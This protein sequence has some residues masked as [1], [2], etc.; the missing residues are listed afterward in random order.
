MD[1]RQDRL[2]KGYSQRE[3]A[4]KL[5]VAERTLRYWESGEIEIPSLKMPEII[6]R[7]K[8]LRLKK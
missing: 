4:L 1:L 6:K 7:A 3:Y 5:G 2:D 8:K